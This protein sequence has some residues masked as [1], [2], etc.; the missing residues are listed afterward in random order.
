MWGQLGDDTQFRVYGHR[1]EGDCSDTELVLRD[2]GD[3]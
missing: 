3:G 1:R 2:K